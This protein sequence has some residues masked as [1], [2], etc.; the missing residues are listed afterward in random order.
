MNRIFPRVTFSVLWISD[1][2]EFHILQ[3]LLRKRSLPRS[4]HAPAGSRSQART[5]NRG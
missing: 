2:R 4:R 1:N 5:P 3:S